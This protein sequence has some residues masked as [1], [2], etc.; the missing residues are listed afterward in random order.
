LR[1][2][3]AMGAVKIEGPATVRRTG[4]LLPLPER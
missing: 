3:G 2:V 1:N 4:R